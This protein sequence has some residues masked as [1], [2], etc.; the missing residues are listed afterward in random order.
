VARE[1]VMASGVRPQ[2]IDGLRHVLDAAAAIRREE[3]WIANDPLQFPR[4]F[5]E[6]LD[7]EAAALFASALAYGR[8]DLFRPQLERLFAVAAKHEGPA[9]FARAA[10]RS[11]SRAAKALGGFGYRMT[12]PEDAAQLLAAVGRAQRRHSSLGAL[13][14]RGFDPADLK[15]SLARFTDALLDGAPQTR[16]MKHLLPSPTRGSSPCKRLNLFLRWM[17]RGPDGVDLGLWRALVPASALLV[18]LDTHILRA[19]R[20]LRLTRRRDLTWKTAEE[21]TRWLR[22]VDPRDPVKYDFALCHLGMEGV[23]FARPE[24][25][26]A[27][28]TSAA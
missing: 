28:T 13:F 23:R 1:V 8:V 9:A 11:P 5:R 12:G 20:D 24:P 25:S 18:P 22:R 19:G 14:A 3:A 16:R 6:P 15:S 10:A 26:R 7:Q 27:R 2:K 4:R 17:V 21:I